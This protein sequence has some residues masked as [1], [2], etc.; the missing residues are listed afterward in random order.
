MLNAEE[1][2]TVVADPPMNPENLC[3][4]RWAMTKNLAFVEVFRTPLGIIGTPCSK[5]G[6]VG[7]PCG[8]KYLR[9]CSQTLLYLEQTKL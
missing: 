9:L 7:G 1:Y 5:H 4:G 8:G 3:L 2:R 6:V